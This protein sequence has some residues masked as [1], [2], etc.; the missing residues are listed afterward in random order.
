MAARGPG[1]SRS[2]GECCTL[3]LNMGW[4]SFSLMWIQEWQIIATA[5]DSL[6]THRLW[7]GSFINA[8][9]YTEIMG[10]G[11]GEGGFWLVC[12][13]N[14]LLWS[15]PAGL[16]RC[17]LQRHCLCIHLKFARLLNPCDIWRFHYIIF[18]KFWE[19][20]QIN[21]STPYKD[22]MRCSFRRQVRKIMR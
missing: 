2:F 9:P 13:G 7:H 12:C 11:R 3:T 18:R 22:L 15:C 16:E 21:I 17:H 8:S 1:V 6:I 10:C 5:P 4:N 19:V 20:L 14:F